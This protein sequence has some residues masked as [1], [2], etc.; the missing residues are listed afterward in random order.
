MCKSQQP[1]PNHRQNIDK[2]HRFTRVKGGRTSLDLPDYSPFEHSRSAADWRSSPMRIDTPPATEA[3]RDLSRCCFRRQS[4]EQ[5]VSLA[6]MAGRK[7]KYPTR[8][9]RIIHCTANARKSEVAGF[10]ERYYH[11]LHPEWAERPQLSP[12]WVRS[13]LGADRPAYLPFVILPCH[14]G[15]C[16]C[17][18]VRFVHL[19]G[20][21]PNQTKS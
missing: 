5:R 4:T 17:C 12:S 14:G 21:G 10:I 6:C 2:P 1:H 20:Q 13:R 19:G 7:A 18:K 3:D 9:E 15:C 11:S 8:R 16:C